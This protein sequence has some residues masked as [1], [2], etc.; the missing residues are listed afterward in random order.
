MIH[1]VM[2]VLSSILTSSAGFVADAAAHFDRQAAL[3]RN[4]RHGGQVGGVVVL[5][6]V[7]VDDV[8]VFCARIAESPRL[9]GGVVVINGHLIVIAL[10]QPHG[11]AAAQVD[12][13]EQFHLLP[14]PLLEFV[15]CCPL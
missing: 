10:V 6:A 4:G 11:L 1:G 3:R 14:F 7:E 2:P 5:G 9:G 8:Q 13:G 12:G 15:L